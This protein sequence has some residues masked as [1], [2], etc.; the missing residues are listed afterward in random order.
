MLSMHFH[1]C[2]SSCSQARLLL[3]SEGFISATTIFLERDSL[4]TQTLPLY[5]HLLVESGKTRLQLILPPL[6]DAHSVS[7]PCRSSGFVWLRTWWATSKRSKPTGD[8]E[9]KS[10]WCGSAPS[11]RP[12]PP[13]LMPGQRS[14]TQNSPVQLQTGEPEKH[15]FFFLRKPKK[16]YFSTWSRVES[17]EN[18]RTTKKTKH[19][20]LPHGW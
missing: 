14:S 5:W 3:L 7:L 4:S 18:D 10:M 19:F 16:H 2:R 17:R 20:V 11:H 15:Y 12:P 8:G 9:R 6:V 13:L 1:L